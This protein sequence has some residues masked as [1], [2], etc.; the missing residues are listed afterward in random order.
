MRSS[1]SA[2]D[3]LHP[4][5][6]GFAHRGVHG[7]GIP[8]NSLSAFAAA[9][10]MGAGIECDVRLS[11]DGS[12]VIFHDSNLQRMCGTQLEVDQTPAAL[13][14]GQRLNGTDQYIPSL[15]ELL[16]LV[17]GRVPLI[18]EL[19]TRDRN[20]QALCRAVVSDLASRRGPVGVMSF[21]PRVGRWLKAHA[22]HIRRGLVIR[23]SLPSL[24]RR[25]ELWLADPHFVAVDIA[26]LGRPWVATLRRRM[27]VY[28]WTVRTKAHRQQAEVQA[29]APIWESNG[30]PG[31]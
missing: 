29:D 9:V 22:Q 10:A 8:E 31:N 5:P 24:R 1:P 7:R 15:W 25:F 30:R 21:D 26:A 6:A 11:G 17:D 28:S 23:D 16:D 2:A 12:A 13:L 4:G 18:L 27:P 20:A 19:K 14:L 3:P